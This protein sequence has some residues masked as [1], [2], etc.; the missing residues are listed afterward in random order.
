LDASGLQ[1][2]HV[3]VPSP[4]EFVAASKR[5]NTSASYSYALDFF[6]SIRENRDSPAY[7]SSGHFSPD[8]NRALAAYL[9]KWAKQSLGA[10]DR[11]GRKDAS[12]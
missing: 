1:L 3:P 12:D 4:A 9:A 5:E 7:Q 2:T 6:R 11:M 8:G 10:T